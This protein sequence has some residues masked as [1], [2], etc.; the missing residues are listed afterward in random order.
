MAYSDEKVWTVIYAVLNCMCAYRSFPFRIKIYGRRLIKQGGLLRLALANTLVFAP[1][2]SMTCKLSAPYYHWLCLFA[3]LVWDSMVIF[4]AFAL[5]I[6]KMIWMTFCFVL[7]FLHIVSRS[8]AWSHLTLFGKSLDGKIHSLQWESTQSITLHVG[9][10]FLTQI[11]QWVQCSHV[12]LQCWPQESCIVWKC[13]LREMFFMH[14]T[15]LT[16][17]SG[18][19]FT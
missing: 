8:Q 6:M 2:Q 19:F 16:I 15:L 10:C 5:I 17:D 1:K 12:I 14:N 3:T 18:P 4:F 9:N 11:L 13:L 7:V